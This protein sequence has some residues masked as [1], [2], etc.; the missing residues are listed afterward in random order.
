MPKADLRSHGRSTYRRW[1]HALPPGA[2]RRPRRA[3]QARA[4]RPRRRRHR[5]RRAGGVRP[6]HD[7]GVVAHQRG[8]RRGGH[9]LRRRGDPPADRASRRPTASTWRP[10]GRPSPSTSTTA[11]AASPGSWASRMQEMLNSAN[12]ALLMAPLLTQGAIDALAPPRHRGAARGV[13][14][15]SM[16]TG[17]WTGTMNLTEP[18]AGSDVGALRTK[19]VPQDDGSYRI[20]GHEDLHHL[21][22]ARPHR[23]HRPPRPRP[24]PGRAAGH[25][26]HLA[27]SSSRSSSSTTTA[28]LGERNDVHVRLDRAQDGHQGQPHVRARLRRRRRRRGR[29]PRRR[30]ERRHAVHV[31]DDEQRPPRR[32][33][34]RASA[35]AERAYQRALEYAQERRQGRAPGRAGRASSR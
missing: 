34:S 3:D 6:A 29:L 27:A 1:R 22:R 24:H 17:E 16:V 7:R 5:V 4:L 13:P 18:E 20:T 10:A 12:M 15:A 28:R 19:A 9:H 2:R 8:R 14:R 23:Q 35:L 25:E 21:R 30:G 32:R 33:A 26:G 11:A 31:H